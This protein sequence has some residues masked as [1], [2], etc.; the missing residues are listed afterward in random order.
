MPPFEATAEGQ[1]FGIGPVQLNSS[2][3][4]SPENNFRTVPSR[5]MAADPLHPGVVY[6]AE[7]IDSEDAAGNIVDRGDIVFSFSTDYGVTWHTPIVVNDDN[8]NR[9]P[10]G[11]LNDVAADQVDVRLSVSPDGKIGMVWLDTRND[12]ANKLLNVFATVGT[13]ST[14]ASGN[15]AVTFS[16]N[17]RVT[18]QAFNADSGQFTD[19][20]GNPNFYLG[21][22]IGMAM[23]EGAMYVSWTDTRNGNQDVYFSRVSLS[24]IPAPPN[25]RFEPNDAPAAATQLGTVVIRHLPQLALSAHDDDWF[26]FR[27]LATGQIDVTVATDRAD[28][29]QVD[30]LDSAGNVIL[31]SGEDQRDGSGNLI[32]KQF[33]ATGQAGQSYLV[34]VYRTSGAA[35]LDD[36]EYSLELQ[37]LTGT[38]GSVVHQTVHGELQ[39]NEQVYYLLS[40]A[41]AG[42]LDAKVTFANAAQDAPV[43]EFLDPRNPTV[44]LASSSENLLELKLPVNK[45]QELLVHLS[46]GSTDQGSF[47]IDFTNL[48]QYS[49]PDLNLFHFPAGSFPSQETVAD[50]NRDGISDVAVADAGDNTVSVLLANGDGTFQAP[51]QFAIGASQFPNPEGATFNQG[52]FRRAIVSADF[53]DDGIIDVA[54]TNYDSGDVSV[55]LGRGDGTFQPERRFDAAPA[56]FA[57]AVGDVNNDG[58]QDLVVADAPLADLGTH[59]A[60]LLGRGDGTFRAQKSKRRP[61]AWPMQ[62]CR[63]SN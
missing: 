58:N 29:L 21:D 43:V 37:S 46:G 62:A 23:T 28:E 11:T 59:L 20:T 9:H 3:A 26:Q 54:V 31:A 55:L 39:S 53:N 33:S 44:V 56:A 22:S 17:F 61:P 36:V 35:N 15:A 41:A 42:S 1:P 60:I 14:D 51:R 7:A 50:F 24:P 38:V 12:P 47:V 40:S 2:Y 27:S 45:G 6:A 52:G 57:L 49:D 19:A 8:S 30:L 4:L 34:H 32:G 10:T 5:S 48:D 13:F 25:D 16:P 63:L 18:D